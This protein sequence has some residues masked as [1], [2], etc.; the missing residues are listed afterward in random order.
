LV[1]FDSNIKATSSSINPVFRS[2][3]L[4]TKNMDNKIG[5]AGI[6]IF[7]MA[8]FAYEPQI[9]RIRLNT[10]KICSGARNVESLGISSRKLV[11][12][13]WETSSSDK[14]KELFF[15]FYCILI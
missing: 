2:C 14:D 5:F 13:H 12:C 1:V 9:E 8:I 10:V 7:W 3:G 6:A 15:F 11:D 4:E